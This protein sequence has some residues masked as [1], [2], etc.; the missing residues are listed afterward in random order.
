MDN[1]SKSIPGCRNHNLYAKM[2]IDIREGMGVDL[3]A[4]CRKYPPKDGPFFQESRF[5]EDGK[6]SLPAYESGIKEYCSSKCPAYEK[7]KSPIEY[8][9]VGTWHKCP[10]HCVACSLRADDE[11]V[12][13]DEE[14]AAYLFSLG[15]LNAAAKEH[16]ERF[17][18]PG[19]LV[20]IGGAGDIFYSENYRKML[21]TDLRKYGMD[22]I[23]IMTNMQRW[24]PRNIEI[25]SEGVA[26]SLRRVSFPV[27]SVN[28]ARYEAIRKGSSWR[29][30]QYSYQRCVAAFP[31]IEYEIIY[32]LSRLNL[33]AYEK[34]PAILKE[35]FP[36]VSLITLKMARSDVLGL[37]PNIQDEARRWCAAYEGNGF[38]LVYRGL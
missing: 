31:G 25:L 8:I 37:P 1:E 4:P 20:Q 27:D 28:P 36:E 22:N 19:P 18:L 38:K 5:I 29:R 17:H 26:K 11:P 30:L 23:G 35:I 13:P 15:E 7:G 3:L 2:R 24:L 33:H 14:M 34:A 12:L 9:I 10:L 32:T 16:N 21:S 6:F